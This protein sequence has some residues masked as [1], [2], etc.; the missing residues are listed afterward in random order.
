MTTCRN[1]G[2]DRP[3]T[4]AVAIRAGFRLEL[5]PVCDSCAAS[6]RAMGYDIHPFDPG[7]PEW[8][9]RAREDGRG[10]PARIL[11]RGVA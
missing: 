1:G 11:E 2:C 9:R 6:L 10:L 7:Q 8:L 4:V 3:A 5:R